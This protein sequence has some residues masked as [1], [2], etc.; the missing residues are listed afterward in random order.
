[1]RTDAEVRHLFRGHE[2]HPGDSF[3][4]SAANDAPP[5]SVKFTVQETSSNP[6]TSA[7]L[8]AS[9][10]MPVVSL[11]LGITGNP[12]PYIPRIRLTPTGEFHQPVQVFRRPT[13]LDQPSIFVT[14]SSLTIDDLVGLWN[15]VSLTSAEEL[16]LRA[17]KFID[18]E[19]DRIAVQVATGNSYYRNGSRGGFIVKRRGTERPVPIGSLGDGMWRM[20]VMAIAITQCRGGVLLIDEIDTGLHYSVMSDMWRLIFNAAKELDVQV[21]ATTHSYDCVYSL[22][23]ICAD[24]DE[25]N[26]ITVQRIEAGKSTA[27]PYAQNEIKIAAD[28]EIEVR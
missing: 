25:Q 15:D 1:M 16:V 26:P 14:S 5:R 13:G 18:P 21:F 19:I 2:I 8:T 6:K 12:P 20:L 27:I 17:L 3:T 7:E 10:G 22:A 4:I 24:A 23:H 9:E 28:R 11:A